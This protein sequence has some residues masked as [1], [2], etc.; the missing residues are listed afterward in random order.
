MQLKNK[1]FVILVIKLLMYI[2]MKIRGKNSVCLGNYDDFK[3]S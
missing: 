1:L 2:F 3:Y